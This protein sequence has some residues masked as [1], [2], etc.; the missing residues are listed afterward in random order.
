L[1]NTSVRIADAANN[2]NLAVAL[3]RHTRQARQAHHRI[4]YPNRATVVK[5]RCE[6]SFASQSCRG[7]DEQENDRPRRGPQARTRAYQPLTS[8]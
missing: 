4:G 1:K 6:L 5:A 3:P 8:A 2:D 7:G